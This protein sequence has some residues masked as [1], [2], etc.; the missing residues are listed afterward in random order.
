MDV[1]VQRMLVVVCGR[2]KVVSVWSYI[3]LSCEMLCRWVMIKSFSPQTYLECFNLIQNNQVYA[4][5]FL[6]LNL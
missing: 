6:I 4:T 5:M 3:R 1:C 2:D